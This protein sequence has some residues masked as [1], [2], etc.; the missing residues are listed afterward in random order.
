MNASLESLSGGIAQHRHMP[1]AIKHQPVDRE[2]ASRGV[3]D[4]LP[5]LLVRSSS[6]AFA[7]EADNLK[8]RRR[9][10]MLLG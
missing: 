6:R 2:I 9:R 7:T 5:E 10:F 8:V 1:L 3:K 4:G